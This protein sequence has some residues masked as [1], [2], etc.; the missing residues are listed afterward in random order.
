MDISGWATDRLCPASSK[1]LFGLVHVNS[2]AFFALKTTSAW[3][4]IR[5]SK[6][7]QR[8]RI[9]VFSVTEWLIY[10]AIYQFLQILQV[11]RKT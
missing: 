6:A 11:T 7:A 5:Y 4:H 8:Y 2:N 9:R 1:I 10:R 3:S